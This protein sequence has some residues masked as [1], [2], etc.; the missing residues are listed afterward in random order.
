[1]TKPSVFIA[2]AGLAVFAASAVAQSAAPLDVRTTM[3]DQVN[4]AMLAIWEVGNNALN[5]EG[6][7]DPA[8]MD[9]DKWGRVAKAADQL[10][11]AG[12]AMA[13][14]EGF[15]AA[16]PNNTMVAE[17]EIAMATVQQHLDADPAG[18]RQMATAFAEHS[19]RLAA[20]ARTQDAG[21]AGD[22]IAGMDGLCE[23]C[24]SR[25]WYPE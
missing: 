15:V 25:Y 5:E 1:M 14:A 8:L 22:L 20:A 21:T 3:Q 19:E 12:N 17:G 9:A 13:A 11:I 16:S 18:L 2:S 7:I 6:G 23:S 10:A 24:H 4:P